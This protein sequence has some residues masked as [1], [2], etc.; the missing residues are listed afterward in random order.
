MTVYSDTRNISI[1][2]WNDFIMDGINVLSKMFCQQKLDD[3]ARKVDSFKAFPIISDGSKNTA[4]TTS[5]LAGISLLLDDM[6]AGRLLSPPSDTTDAVDLLLHPVL[7]KDAAS[8]NWAQNVY[9]IALA[10]SNTVSPMAWTLTQPPIDLQSTLS[11]RGRLLAVTRF[12]YL[13]VS[14]IGKPPQSFNTYVNEEVTL[15]TG[16]AA[17]KGINLKFYMSSADKTP[18]A[19]VNVDDPWS[20]FDFYLNKNVITTDNGAFFPVFI[21]DTLGQYVYF[22]AI[23][24]NYNIPAPGDWYSSITW[25]NLRVVDG[26]VAANP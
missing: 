26:M 11:M 18:Q 15:A 13:E 8:R 20:I 25:P 7:F 6:G 3:F 16:M 17:D 10:A 2:W 9:E 22:M 21:N 1:G 19:T 23:K 24:F 14:T 12:R 5:V 4:L